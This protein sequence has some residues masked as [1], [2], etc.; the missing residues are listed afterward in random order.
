MMNG[1]VDDG[2]GWRNI[3]VALLVKKEQQRL[4]SF[5]VIYHNRD[6]IQVTWAKYTYTFILSS[7]YVFVPQRQM[8]GFIYNNYTAYVH[9][10]LF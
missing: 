10:I 6:P 1:M 9:Y 3:F 5:F 4:T 7:L 8:V 2:D